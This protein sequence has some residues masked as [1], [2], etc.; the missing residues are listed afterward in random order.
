[1]GAAMARAVWSGSISFGLVSVAVKAYTAVRDHEVRFHQIDKKSGARV[2][3][4]KVSEKTHRKLD[5]EDIEMGFELRKGRYVAFTKEELSDLRPK[6]TRTVEVSDFVPLEDIDPIYYERTYWLGPDGPGAA[7]AYGLLCAA[8]EDRQRVGVGSVVMRNKQ[9]LAAIRPLE[10]VLAMSTLRFADEVVA[11]SEVDGL[12]ARA[13]EAGEVSRHLHRRAARVDR[14]AGKGRNRRHRGLGSQDSRGPRSHGSTQRVGRRG[15]APPTWRPR[16]EEGVAAQAVGGHQN[17]R[18]QERLKPD[19]VTT[20]IRFRTT[21]VYR[22]AQRP[23][24]SAPCTPRQCTTR[25]HQ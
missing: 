6:S 21:R 9:Y 4:E 16:Q 13:M 24:P 22:W 1:M 11:R 10:G 17:G 7:R 25:N 3:Y 14:T 8:M 5:G 12:P 20:W 19:H 2:R 15:E 18:P 23:Y